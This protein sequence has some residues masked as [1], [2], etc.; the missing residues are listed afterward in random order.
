MTW[1][2]FQER[3]IQFSKLY[4]GDGLE[5]AGHSAVMMGKRLNKVIVQVSWNPEVFESVVLLLGGSPEML[6]YLAVTLVERLCKITTDVSCD[7]TLL[8]GRVMVS[9]LVVTLGWGTTQLLLRCTGTEP[10]ESVQLYLGGDSL[11]ISG[12]LAVSLETDCIVIVQLS[13][14]IEVFKS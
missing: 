10:F 14:N 2:V 4:L 11:E 3:A 5:M 6:G 9:H 1:L 12:H 7:R 13:W 8:V